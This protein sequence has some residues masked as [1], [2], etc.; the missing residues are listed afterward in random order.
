MMATFRQFPV[1]G[2]RFPSP[3]PRGPE[4]VFG[5]MGRA[6]PIARDLGLVLWMI[7]VLAFWLIVIAG[8]VL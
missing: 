7:T 8:C 3:K 6:L 5:A 4:N 2:F 1:V